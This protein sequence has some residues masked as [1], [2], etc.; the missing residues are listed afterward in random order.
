[1]LTSYD[2]Q[3]QQGKDIYVVDKK[4]N[5]TY[6]VTHETGWCG[7]YFNRNNN[8]HGAIVVSNKTERR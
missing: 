5:W 6:V 3:N 1:M 2:L 7:P 4:F 8:V